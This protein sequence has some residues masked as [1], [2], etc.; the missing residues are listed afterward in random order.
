MRCYNCC[1]I[2]CSKRENV[3]KATTRSTPILCPFSHLFCEWCRS[4]L[5]VWKPVRTSLKQPIDMCFFSRSSSVLTEFVSIGLLSSSDIHFYLSVNDSIFAN[6]TLG[7][8]LA[9]FYDIHC[10]LF[11]KYQVNILYKIME[12]WMFLWH[13]CSYTFNCLTNLT[14]TLPPKVSVIF[15]L[16]I[17]QLSITID[18]T[19]LPCCF[20]LVHKLSSPSLAVLY[21]D[22]IVSCQN[23]ISFWMMKRE[24]YCG[25]HRPLHI[26]P[27]SLNVWSQ[28]K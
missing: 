17:Q 7:G 3:D 20:S 11:F 18:C 12:I 25:T 27:A 21:T 26:I 24:S 5:L 28:L 10:H 8:V 22:L 19:L 15:F 16:H 2:S 1:Y 23:R 9:A 14:W 4:F 6:S 13:S